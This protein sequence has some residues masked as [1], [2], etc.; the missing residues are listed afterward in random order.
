MLSALLNLHRTG[1]LTVPG[2]CRTLEGVMT[3]GVNMMAMLK[4]A[5][6]L[7]PRRIAITDDHERLTYLELWRQSEALAAALQSDF[8][9][10]PGHKA[11]LACRN[12]AAFIKAIFA[13]S[14]LGS[15]LY[16]ISP[17]MRVDQ[18]HALDE[19]LR[20]DFHIH[21]DPL[22]DLGPKSLPAYRPTGTSI[23]R[24]SKQPRPTARLKR[25][26]G[27][28][29]VLMTGG[30]T[31][32]PKPASRKP[33]LFD[34]LPPLAALLGK[35]KLGDC[36]SLYVAPPIYHSYGLSALAIGILLGAEIHTA[37]RFDA[38]RACEVIARRRIDMLVTIPLML[39][40][41]LNHDAVALSSLRQIFCGADVLT[42]ALAD[43]TL[44]R[45]GPILFNTYGTA[46]GGTVSLADATELRRKPGTVG[47]PI[48]GVRLRLLD[49]AGREVGTGAVGRICVSSAWTA[50]EKGWV[51]TGDLG[52]R[53]ADGYCFLCGRVDDM[54]VSGGENV[55]PMELENVL[56]RHEDVAAVAA[57]GIPDAEFGWRLKAVV[58]V[59]PGRTADRTALID[60]LKPR[61]A[62]HQMPAVIEFRDDLPCTA[63]GKP[64]KKA[65]QS[66]GLTICNDSDGEAGDGA[67]AARAVP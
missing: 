60:W 64:D 2:L 34:F 6:R 56:A 31:G 50:N 9:V 48:R 30:T 27:G 41:M 14:R 42:P 12:H 55:Y 1:L 3:T 57:V 19:R 52:F 29:I 67:G 26:R 44:A 18:F 37:A 33:S 24:L 17:G 20:F 5:A 53:D 8:G 36:L 28:N 54:I 51:E 15:H 63:V 32:Q 46:E 25:V 10:G 47:K 62:R 39:R 13:F 23:D 61:I 49:E 11:A 45:L 22:V 65:L 35:L 66:G 43:E 16:F 21:D 58:V 4:V 59:H 7:F 38:A 40:R